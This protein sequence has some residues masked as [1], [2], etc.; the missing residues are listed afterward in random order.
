MKKF[1]SA[2][3]FAV[4]ILSV[5]FCSA[6]YYDNSPDY[7]RTTVGGGYAVY[8]F[9]KSVDV[10]K[11]NPPHYQIACN[12]IHVDNRSGKLANKTYRVVRYNYYT[13]ESFTLDRYGD[14]RKNDIYANSADRHDAIIANALFRVAYGMNFYN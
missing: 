4:C 1:L 12:L 8:I 3:V 11:Y 10:Q 7:Y 5:N 2:L 9:I 6:N 13:K 14:W